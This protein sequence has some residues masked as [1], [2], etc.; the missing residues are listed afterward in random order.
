MAAEDL[1]QA[2]PVLPKF[3]LTK[4]VPVCCN[5]AGNSMLLRFPDRFNRCHLWLPIDKVAQA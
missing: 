1:P 4:A 5:D 2:A 3:D